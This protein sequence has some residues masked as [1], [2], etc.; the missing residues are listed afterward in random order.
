VHTIPVIDLTPARRSEAGAAHVAERIGQACRNTGFFQIIGHGVPTELVNTMFKVTRQFF[1]LTADAKQ[2][3]RQPAADQGRGWTGV[4]SEGISYSLDEESAGDLKEKFDIGPP[5]PRRADA[6][7]SPERS[8]PHFAPNLWPAELP[9]LRAPW[10]LYYGHLAQVGD[11]LMRLCARALGASPEYFDDKLDRA[12]SGL[13]A[14]YYPDQPEPP[15]PGQLRAG[16]HTDYG[17]LT[18]INA[19]DRPGGLQ[20]LDRD[21]EWLDVPV[22]ADALMV[23]IGDLL[24][25]W[26]ADRWPATLH[27]VVNPPRQQAMESDRLAFAFYLHPNYDAL[28]EPLPGLGPPVTGPEALIAGEYVREQYLRQTTFGPR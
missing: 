16:V 11:E 1:A 28:V 14:I 8:G 15:L 22:I 21:G 4:G 3:V 19:E 26:T 27:R 9:A 13:R 20:V 7:Y 18:L 17:S 24:A 5:L 2:R 10:E 6:Y 23:N 12:V 25:E